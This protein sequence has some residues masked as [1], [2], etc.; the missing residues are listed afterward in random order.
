M[1][2]HCF[3]TLLMK[4][5]VIAPKV[6]NYKHGTRSVQGPLRRVVR[7]GFLVDVGGV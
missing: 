7:V 5:G 4:G 2:V 1:A 6:M 3:K